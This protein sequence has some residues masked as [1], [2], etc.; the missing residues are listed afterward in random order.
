MS[1]KKKTKAATVRNIIDAAAKSFA[2]NGFEGARVDEIAKE[3]GVN[4]ATLY[5]QVGDKEK[6]YES[7]L[8][9]KFDLFAVQVSDAVK[10]G[11][12]AGEKLRAF[13]TTLGRNFGDNRRFASIM[14][15]EVASGGSKLPD[16]V[17]KKM[18]FIIGTLR[19]IL[20]EGENEGVFRKADPF[21]THIQIIGGIMFYVAGEPIRLRAQKKL[22]TGEDLN[23]EI[24]AEDAANHM[25]DMIINSLIIKKQLR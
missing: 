4:K 9:E 7:V 25:A 13:I 22:R 14:M 18:L 2:E 21:L 11:K 1:D 19:S 10:T 24:P 17:F 12:T 5:Y 15:R 16:N 20:E 6:L 23:T 8:M 3:A